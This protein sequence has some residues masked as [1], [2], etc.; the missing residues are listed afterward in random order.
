M[1]VDHLDRGGRGVYMRRTMLMQGAGA[2]RIPLVESRLLPFTLHGRARHNEANA[3]AAIGA[4]WA[5]GYSRRRI[6]AGS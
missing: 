1:L 5:L 6:V 2:H 3:L 4:L